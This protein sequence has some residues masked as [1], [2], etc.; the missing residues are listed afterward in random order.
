MS[1]KCVDASISRPQ[2]L[3]V[4]QNCWL[5]VVIIIVL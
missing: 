4:V 1:A 5:M 2:N 3:H